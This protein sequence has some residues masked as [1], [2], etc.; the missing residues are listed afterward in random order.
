MLCGA[1]CT[2]PPPCTYWAE[3]ELIA[4]PC[5][6]ETS[7]SAGLVSNPLQRDGD[8]RVNVSAPPGL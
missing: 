7:I 1:R 2:S 3:A 5:K 4:C 6:G 8:G